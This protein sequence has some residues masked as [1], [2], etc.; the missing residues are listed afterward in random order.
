MAREWL[1]DGARGFQVATSESTECNKR[2]ADGPEALVQRQ[3]RGC[4]ASRVLG[5]NIWNTVSEVPAAQLEGNRCDEGFVEG[6][7][8]SWWQH[9]GPTVLDAGLE[10]RH[11]CRGHHPA[12]GDVR[13][14][15]V[16]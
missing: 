8:S 6:I 5:G 14:T 13:S 11:P 12:R 9:R 7:G 3:Q 4:R 10:A 2:D 16:R 1:V 15:F